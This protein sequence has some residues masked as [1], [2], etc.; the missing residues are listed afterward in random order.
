MLIGASNF[1]HSQLAPLPSSRIGMMALAKVLDDPQIGGFDSVEF[2]SDGALSEVTRAVER[3]V[4]TSE[5]DDLLLLYYIGHGFLADNGDLR[6]AVA[7]SDPGLQQSTLAADRLVTMAHTGPAGQAVIILDCCYSGLDLGKWSRGVGRT[8]GRSDLWVLSSSGATEVSY[9]RRIDVSDDPDQT[10]SVFT[11]IL[12]DGLRSGSADLDGD[13]L[14]HIDELAQYVLVEVRKLANQTPVLV[15]SAS[16]RALIARVPTAEPQ[17]P[18][19][20]AVGI[21]GYGDRPA[22]ED[23]LRRHGMLQAFRALVMPQNNVRGEE[24]AGPTVIALD[25]AWGVGKTSVIDL[26]AK[27]LKHGPRLDVPAEKVGRMSVW[28]ARKALGGRG[29]ALWTEKMVPRVSENGMPSLVTSRFE[30]WAHQ[31]GEQVWAGITR[32]LLG[33]VNE[34]F[35]RDDK[36]IERYWFQRN[37]ERVDRARLRRSL[38]KEAASPL[39]AVALLA[40]LTPIIAQMARS[41][42][43]YR[44]LGLT[45]VMGANIAWIIVVVALAAGTGNLIWRYRRPAADYLPAELFVGPI[46]S[47]AFADNNGDEAVRD[48]YRNARSGYLYLLQHDVFAALDDM[49]E[50]GHH[51]VLFVDDLDRCSSRTTAEVFE[52]INLFV[53]RT[54]P[55][56]RFVL[57]LDS[58]AVAAHLDDTY[59]A[60]RDKPLD[61]DDPSPGWSFL[62][63]LIQLTIPIPAISPDVLDDLV[64]QLLPKPVT[65]AHAQTATA[66]ATAEPAQGTTDPG[67]QHTFTT[68]LPNEAKTTAAMELL[69]HDDEVRAR[70]LERLR[71]QPVRSVREVKRILTVWQYFVRVLI[72]LRTAQPVSVQE[73]KQL[74]VLAE[75]SA[76]W[77]AAQR[78]LHRSVDGKCGLESLAAVVDNDLEWA[79]TLRKLGLHTGPHEKCV[80]GLR[81]LLRRYNGVRLA[82]LA[83]E[84]H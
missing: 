81:E 67:Q 62:R 5:P 54:F 25:G 80:A 73:A 4:E 38:L 9:D 15:Q 33:V 27:L 84:L 56:T 6:L 75:I 11:G 46:N 41:T 68:M 37:I 61:T 59:S 82:E 17:P 71:D 48:P 35:L 14:V 26:S 76:R 18:T 7:D 29:D 57:C 36:V 58:A 47:T 13:G 70:I 72:V 78:T 19:R 12:V 79:Q 16:G 65:H 39:F 30:P 53:N 32:T 1:A 45:E 64:D 21:R 52:A 34:R 31:T 28:E 50:A 63:K 42:D 60:L 3:L 55:V 69:E 83:A 43:V 40:L 20:R 51:I 10:G 66:Q 23:L 49:K 24:Y 74:V 44:V 77:P 8:Y 22:T 2:H